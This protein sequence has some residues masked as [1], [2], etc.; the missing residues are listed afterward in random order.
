MRQE[1]RALRRSPLTASTAREGIPAAEQA[2]LTDTQTPSAANACWKA[3]PRT[4]CTLR[5]RM[6]GTA[7]SGLLMRTF[8]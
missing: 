2:D 3:S 1:E 8:G 4:P 6:C 7:L 5:F